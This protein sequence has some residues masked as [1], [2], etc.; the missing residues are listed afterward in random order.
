MFI[1][2]VNFPYEIP[3]SYEGWQGG[4]Y[5]LHCHK[6]VIELLMVIK[7]KAKVVISCET[8]EMSEGDYVVIRESDS[9]SYSAAESGCEIVSL[10]IRMQDYLEKIPYLYYVIFACES[11]DLAKY[12]NE[13][14]RIRKM[15]I[16][17]CGF[18]STIMT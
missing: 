14:A 17:F 15:Q 10:Y 16:I 1:E 2:K 13:T 9:H 11:F 3:I 8:F 5:H 4:S 12:R 6:D 7:G 18:L